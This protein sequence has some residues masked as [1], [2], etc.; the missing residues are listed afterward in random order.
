[1][2]ISDTLYMIGWFT[3]ALLTVEFGQ[4]LGRVC[5]M[6]SRHSCGENQMVNGSIQGDSCNF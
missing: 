5:V 3:I 2:V 1:M 6:T 4:G